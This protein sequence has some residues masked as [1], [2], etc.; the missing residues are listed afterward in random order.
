MTRWSSEPSCTEVDP[1]HLPSPGVHS[2][3]GQLRWRIAP[4]LSLELRQ[5]HP[6]LSYNMVVLHSAQNPAGLRKV[7]DATLG[8]LS[9]FLAS[10]P[11]T[12]VGV[13]QMGARQRHDISEAVCS[14]KGVRLCDQQAGSALETDLRGPWQTPVWPTALPSVLGHS[15]GEGRSCRAVRSRG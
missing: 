2:A 6:S 8:I 4:S 12:V 7:E 15:P 11:L 1:C 5:R 3:Q 9:L 13:D 10:P 14:Q